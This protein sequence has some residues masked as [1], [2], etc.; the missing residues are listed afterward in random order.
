MPVIEDAAEALGATYRGRPAGSFGR[1]GVFSF[2][3]NK[4]IT[5]SGGGMLVADDPDLVHRARFLAQQARDDAPHYEHHVTGFNYRMSNLLAAV[6]RAQLQ[7][8]PRRVARRRA[9]NQRYRE[10]LGATPGIGFMPNDPRGEPTNW[11]TVATIDAAEFGATPRRIREHLE[12]M[13][14]E[15]QTRLEA[16]A[17]PTALREGAGARR[18]VRGKDLPHRSVSPQRVGDERRRRGSRRRRCARGARMTTADELTTRRA[19]DADLD[20]ILE[21]ARRALGWSDDD[22][23][24]LRWKHFD[25]AFGVSPMWVAL[26]GE[27]VA[28]FRSFMRWEF[29]APGRE[30]LRAARAVDTATDPDY[31]GRGIFTR[32]TLEAI[33]EL[34]DEGVAFIFNTPN[35]KSRPGYLKMGWRE[36]GRLPVAVTPARAR[37]ALVLHT[38]RASAGRWPVVTSVGE[39]P[40]DV[41]A[42]AAGLTE[43]LDS[44]PPP[45]ACA[46]RRSVEFL[47]WRYGYEPL[48]YRVVLLGSS[49]R[50]GVAVF[51]CRRRGQ[52]VEAAVCDV[53]VPGDDPRARGR[54]LRRLRAA[55]DADYLMAIDPRPIGP[56]PL[57][58]VPRLGPILTARAL[59]DT[60]PVALRDWALTLG[61]VELF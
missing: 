14:I 6:G 56:G 19:V 24:F 51:R 37:A 9:I 10:L 47:T 28:G 23:A 1:T 48:G 59:A 15:A 54:V 5:T 55:V 4:I 12:T 21:L 22:T 27:R 52:A 60:P 45:R 38:A 53:I 16:D 29:S 2:N 39:A 35:E 3:G 20:S 18:G 46:T 43:L 57:V 42:D 8:L 25:N 41:F 26:D 30:R 34:R 36:V 44:Q 7:G 17:P 33:E 61:D 58:R 13:D 50:S 31:Q 11:L 32:L 40:A 49:A